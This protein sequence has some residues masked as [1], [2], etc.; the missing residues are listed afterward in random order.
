MS[1]DTNR[2]CTIK[3]MLPKLN[4]SA[5]IKQTV[6]VVADVGN[7]DLIIRRSLLQELG[8]VLNFENNTI[9]WSN[10][11]IIMK[12]YNCAKETSYDIEEPVH[13]ED[14]VDRIAKILEAK[15]KPAN[16]VEIATANPHLSVDRKQQL[17]KLLSVHKDMFNGTLGTGKIPCLV[18]Q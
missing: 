8:I 6:H 10:L 1:V 12:P 9:R 5:I 14:A 17:L 11:E 13:T 16:L 3:F 2:T 4:Q 18:I 15:Y 7:Y